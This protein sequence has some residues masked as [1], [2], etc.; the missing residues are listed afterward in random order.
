MS[1]SEHWLPGKRAEQVAMAKDWVT[2]LKSPEAASWNVPAA[3]VT[4]LEALT[5]AAEVILA[6]AEGRER[7]MV[8]TEQCREAFEAMVAKMRYIKNRFFFVPPLTNANLVGLGLKAEK[9]SAPILAPDAQ[10][11]A[12]VIY[13][14]I[15]LLELRIRPVAGFT[16][17]PRSDYGFRI[18]YG[19]MP[20]GGASIEAA[21]GINRELVKPP[22]SGKELPHSVFTRRKRE[23]FDFSAE[24]SGKRV[25]FCIHY[26]NAKGDVGPFGPIFSAIIP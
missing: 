23:R 19:I 4:E 16:P 21:L 17:D 20:P 5:T 10:V 3:Q 1:Y 11:E 22:V 12:D 15:H 13:L 24:D 8:I 2:V 9:S 7:T 26:E 18:Y 25:Y 14:G 6:A